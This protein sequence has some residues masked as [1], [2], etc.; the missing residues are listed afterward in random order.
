MF[1]AVRHITLMMLSLLAFVSCDKTIH[2]YPGEANIELTVRCSVDLT[3]PEYF[4]TVECDAENGTSYVVR[5]Q[6]VE[7]QGTR[8]T[9]P[10]C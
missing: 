6:N 8:F 5:A 1:R 2:E 9:E 3:P 10:V 4:A 7:P